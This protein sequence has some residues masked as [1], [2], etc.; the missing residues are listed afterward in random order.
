MLTGAGRPILNFNIMSE[1]IS[2]NVNTLEDSSGLVMAEVV[3][4][5][6]PK[7]LFG[8]SFYLKVGGV[9]WGYEGYKNGDLFAGSDPIWLVKE[10]NGELIFGVTLKRADFIAGKEKFL[11]GVSGGGGGS[12]GVSG[13][14]VSFILKPHSNGVLNFEF[15]RPVLS[16]FENG[17]SDL[18][19]VEWNGGNMEVLNIEESGNKTISEGEETG[20]SLL[21]FSDGMIN[22]TGPFSRSEMRY[23]GAVGGY[24][25]EIGPVDL[26]VYS[27]C[28]LLLVLG[29]FMGYL[30]VK[31]RL[32]KQ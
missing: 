12:E 11:G 23:V 16:V 21:D 1:Q 29:V 17:R 26:F 30:L 22:V 7:N 5:N 20:G 25:Q 32:K 3:I 4:D 31:R 9:E 18:K 24:D 6:A 28:G 8:A 14:L 27:F 10:R 15:V 2:V 13:K 19:N